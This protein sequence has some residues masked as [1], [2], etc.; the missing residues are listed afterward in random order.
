[1]N[2]KF[3]IYG[4]PVAKARARYSAKTRSFYTPGKTA[5]YEDLVAKSG[6]IAMVGRQMLPGA[7]RMTVRIYL[8]IPKSWSKKKRESAI[9]GT[10]RPITKPDCSNILKAVEDGL[11]GIVY[12]DDAQIV[13]PS[14]AKF[15]SDI[16]RC[17]VEIA[18]VLE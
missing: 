10:I 5:K 9:S 18:T 2:V 11:N 15:Y 16:P 8:E 4:N 1:M 17:E 13:E 3:T 14:C 12:H 7:L 6:M